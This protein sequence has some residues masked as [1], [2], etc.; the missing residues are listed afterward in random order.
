MNTFMGV[1]MLI[2]ALLLS[3]AATMG[4]VPPSTAQIAAS[5]FRDELARDTWT[6]LRSPQTGVRSVQRPL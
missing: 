1:L 4:T 6:Y 3:C 2:G 5:G